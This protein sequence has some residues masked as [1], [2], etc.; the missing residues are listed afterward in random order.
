MLFD[1]ISPLLEIYL[2][3]QSE[4]HTKVIVQS[5]S[6]LIPSEENGNKLNVSIKIKRRMT[7]IN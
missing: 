4:M 7:G 6:A 5:V 1:L 2:R 3:S